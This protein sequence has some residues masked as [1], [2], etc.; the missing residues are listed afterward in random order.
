MT[1]KSIFHNYT[2]QLLENVITAYRS[3][4]SLFCKGTIMEPIF[5]KYFQ[6]FLFWILETKTD[7]KEPC[8]F[9]SVVKLFVMIALQHLMSSNVMNYDVSLKYFKILYHLNLL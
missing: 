4:F 1:N 8:C 7:C 6:T 2:V 3:K 9:S 5:S